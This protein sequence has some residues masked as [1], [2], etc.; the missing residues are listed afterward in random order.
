[1]SVDISKVEVVI[2]DYGNTLIELG[3]DQ[4]ALLNDAFFALTTSIFGKCDMDKFTA[5]RKQQILA[6]YDTDEF[7]EN[8]RVGICIEL[9]EKLYG[10]TP[11]SEH[12]QKMLDLKHKIFVDVIEAPSFVIPLLSKLQEKY[13]LAFISNYP[14]SASIA[15][16]LNKNNLTD[17]FESI[18]ISAD[19]G[20]VKPH[21]EIFKKSLNELNLPAKNCLYVGDNWLADIQGAKRAGMQAVHTTQYV[22][23][24]KFEPYEG[25]YSPDAVIGHLKELEKILLYT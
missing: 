20:R 16:S 21:P 4:V 1:M 3:A 11:S 17:F 6:P 14:C 9:I 13:R 18:I 23:Y 7:I 8:D 2:F 24:E 22:S 5:I 12:I 10:I 25:D 15:D 19:I